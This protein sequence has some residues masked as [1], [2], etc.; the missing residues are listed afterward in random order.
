MIDSMLPCG[1]DRIRRTGRWDAAEFPR[2]TGRQVLMSDDPSA[3][4]TFEFEG[5]FLSILLAPTWQ[6]PGPLYGAFGTVRAGRNL[7]PVDAVLEVSVDDLPP[8][9]V[10]LLTSPLEAVVFRGAPAGRHTVTVRQ[11]A[12]R[13]GMVAIEAFRIAGRPLGQLRFG[14]F[15]EESYNLNDLRLEVLQAGQC[16]QRRIV[17]NAR[18]G[19]C[20]VTGLVPGAYDL[21]LFAFGWEPLELK[22][23]VVSDGRDAD[24]GDFYLRRR[25]RGRGG[26]E[27]VIRPGRGRTVSVAPG[28]HFEV[29]CRLK[30]GDAI[31]EA[32]LV[33]EDLRLPIDLEVAPADDEKL[34][35]TF[36]RVRGKI[37]DEVPDD[38]Y[39][40]EVQFDGWAKPMIAAQAVAVRRRWPEDFYLVTFGHTN[41]WGQENAEYLARLVDVVNAIHPTMVL[42]A[43]EVNWAYLTGALGRLRV[44]YC[45]TWGNHSYPNYEHF[46]GPRISAVDAGPIRVVNFGHTWDEDWRSVRRLFENR[47]DAGI[48]II[49]T[50]DSNAPTA[51]L[52]DRC[53]VNLLHDAHGRGVKVEARGRTPTWRVGKVN[54]ESFRLV[55]FRGGEFH[56][57]TYRGEAEAPIPFPRR[58]RSPL[59]VSYEPQPDGTRRRVRAEIDNDWEERFEHARL[60]FRMA[61]GRY[62]VEGGRI[63]QQFPAN[64]RPGTIVDVAVTIRPLGKTIVEV[65]PDPP[66]RKTRSADMAGQR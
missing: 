40:L 4:L 62:R 42:I 65:S 46:F 5:A 21:Q 20:A 56:S 26:R 8:V 51:E 33:S 6:D 52:L 36:L 25:P 17:R 16:V 14:V 23:V 44:P 41:T 35:G 57:A 7:T 49:N 37:G 29:L 50:F 53:K 38:L 24:L 28:G 34:H 60:R 2:T 59:R 39:D 43:N 66:P 31:R 15:G 22:G 30:K 27:G 54:A 55:R 45:I 12:G 64:R 9:P 61:P 3:S 48:R 63:V 19:R 47:P 58:E 18:S 10:G 13:H 32:H 1:S 11:A